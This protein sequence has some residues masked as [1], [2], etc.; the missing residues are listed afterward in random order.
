MGLHREEI[1]KVHPFLVSGIGGTCLNS[2]N[3]AAM[4]HEWIID[5]IHDIEP[6]RS[7]M[8]HL[9]EGYAKNKNFYKSID[10]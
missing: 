4:L 1:D 7:W 3:S 10:E 2:R 8:L 5:S 9:L 6:N